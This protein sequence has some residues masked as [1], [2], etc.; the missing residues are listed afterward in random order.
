M[1][2]S[3]KTGFLLLALIF[4]NNVYAQEQAVCNCMLPIDNS[5]QIAPMTVGQDTD[6]GVPPLYENDNATT[7][8]LHLPF[9]F[10]FFGQ[11]F[12]SVFISNNGIVSFVQPIHSFIDSG[13]GLPFGKDTLMIAPFFADAN[14][15]KNAGIVYYKITPTYMVVTW[16]SVRYAGIDVDGWNIFQLIITNGSDPILPQGNN[17]SFCYPLMQWACSESSGG[18]SGYGGTPAIIGINNGDGIH[19][20]QIGTFSLPGNVYDG[21][22]SPFN[23]VDWLDFNSFTFNTCVASN[24]LAPV[25]FNDRP[26]C[27]TL[28]VCPC[29]TTI[30]EITHNSFHDS[31]TSPP[32]D[33]IRMTGAFICAVPG[34]SATL[35]YSCTGSLNIDSV[36]ISTA[37]FIDSITVEAIPIFADTGM[38]VLS[39][40]ATDPVSQMKSTVTYNIIVTTGCATAGVNR[41]DNENGFSINPNPAYNF[42]TI[43]SDYI[44]RNTVAKIYDVMGTEVLSANLK[45]DK[46]ELDISKLSKGIYFIEILKDGTRALAKKIIIQ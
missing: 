37:N 6:I 44:T 9:N 39:L 11:S 1:K 15:N 46:S 17:V 42:L 32:C 4:H 38:H 43:R 34:Q 7:P 3:I 2:S 13:H 23:G 36:K 28:Y 31:S 24:T 21:P 12:D 35:S 18:F 33:T 5:F 19:Y 25:I 41:V 22:F 26:A 10:C 40:T 29:D 45:S 27:N 16:D 14:T 30:T 20:S 8:A